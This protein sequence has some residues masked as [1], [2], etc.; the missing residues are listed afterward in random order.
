M[1]IKQDNFLTY[2]NQF[3]DKIFNY[4]LYRIGFDKPLA[5]DLTSEVFIKALKAFASFDENQKFQSWIYAI[6][7]NHLI[8]HYA[9]AGRAPVPLEDLEDFIPDT[10]DDQFEEKYEAEQVLQVIDEMAD[11][12]RD[13]LRFRFVDELDY[14]E[15]ADILCKEEGAIRTQVSRSLEKLRQ[16]LKKNLEK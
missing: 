13:I 15:I 16:K 10:N 12:D 14:R 2:Y 6:A 5:E 1:A 11:S 8:N 7:H 3:K 9:R 4:F